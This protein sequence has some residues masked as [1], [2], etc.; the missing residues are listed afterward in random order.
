MTLKNSE[1]EYTLATREKICKP[2]ILILPQGE[3]IPIIQH[4]NP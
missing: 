2:K 1:N 4:I 3:N